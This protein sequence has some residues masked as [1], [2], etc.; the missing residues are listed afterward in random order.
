[1]K[2]S[3]IPLNLPRI[4]YGAGSLT[5]GEVGPSPFRKGGALHNNPHLHNKFGFCTK[6]RFNQREWR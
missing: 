3:K 6:T 5:K 4:K 2:G 1:M